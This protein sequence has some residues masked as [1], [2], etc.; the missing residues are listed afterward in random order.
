MN[1]DCIIIYLSIEPNNFFYINLFEYMLD[2][3][4]I[5]LLIDIDK[6]GILNTIWMQK[7]NIVNLSIFTIL[8]PHFGYLFN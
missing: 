6:C 1:K 4:I 2:N 7:S 3:N 5:Y 8:V